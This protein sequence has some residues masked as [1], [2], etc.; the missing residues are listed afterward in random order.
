MGN[1]AVVIFTN[2][3]ADIFS[4]AIYLHW[5][6]G[7]ESI[8]QF[9]DELD[10]RDV[11]ADQNYEAA[12]FVQIVGEF[13][14][15]EYRSNCSL[16]IDSGPSHFCEVLGH[17]CGDNGIFL[18]CRALAEGRKVRRFWRGAEKDEDWVK[19]ELETA[20]RI[21]V[22]RVFRP[23]WGDKLTEREHH[24]NKGT[25]SNPFPTVKQLVALAADALCK[26]D[27]DWGS[28]RQVKAQNLFFEE[29]ERFGIDVSKWEC[30][31]MSSDEMINACLMEIMGAHR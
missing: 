3:E 2:R 6:G 15:Q 23:V 28:D 24:A 21:M 5:N 19:A 10:R 13:M 18:V 1:R 17:D 8:Y 11:R 29:A 22:K 25:E 31:K 27:D 12:R 16:G 9:L 4:P 26:N 30:A 7:P 14:D 20:S